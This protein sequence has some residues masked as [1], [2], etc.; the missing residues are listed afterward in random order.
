[1]SVRW[2]HRND[3]LARTDPLEASHC[4]AQVTVSRDQQGGV[5]HIPGSVFD[6]LHRDADVSLLLLVGHPPA[7]T[8]PTLTDLL[9][10]AERGW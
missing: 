10:E 5:E 7:T 4:G 6:Q 1:V 3:A 2:K 8:G 9:L